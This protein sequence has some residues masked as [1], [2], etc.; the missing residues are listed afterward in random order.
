MDTAAHY[1]DVA[2]AAAYLSLSTS[3]LT[4]LVSRKKIPHLKIGRRVVFDTR[5]LDRWAARRQVL[6]RDW[7]TGG[8]T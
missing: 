5:L 6:P 8:T 4:K 2:G 1:L 3:Y 7:G